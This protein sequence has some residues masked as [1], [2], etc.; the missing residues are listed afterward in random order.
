MRNPIQP[1][2]PACPQLWKELLKAGLDEDGWQWDFTTLGSLKTPEKPISAQIIAKASGV[3]AAEG[4]LE[5]TNSVFAEVFSG[6]GSLVSS[7][8]K[9]GDRLRVGQAAVSWKGPARAVLALERPFLNLASYVSGIASATRELVD[10]V[11]KA[12]PNRTPRVSATRKTLP[13]YRDLAVYGVVA[14]GGYCHRINLAGGVLI[15]E[16]H[17][18]A[19]GGI[20]RAIVGARA[21]APHGMKIEIEVRS[22]H[23]LTQ[24]LKARADG[25]LLDNF[26]SKE[27][28]EALKQVDG[29]AKTQARPVVEVSGGI[30]LANISDYALAGVDVISSGSL[31]H[32]VKA[33]DLS[34][35]VKGLLLR[36]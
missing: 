24:A 7:V 11:E 30:H 20:E 21:V 6:K 19:A 17:I 13:F 23:E 26:T 22:L 25:V 12:C 16:N 32:S 14:G 36:K 4:L 29:L 33:L 8:C 18:A 31:T 28:K 2:Y 10:A 1:T 15:K 35:L 34:L 3:W 27:V 5:A 9:D